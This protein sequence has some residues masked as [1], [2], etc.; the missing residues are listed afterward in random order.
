MVHADKERNTIPVKRKSR[1]QL[2]LLTAVNGLSN[3][4]L[5]KAIY[6]QVW[7]VLNVVKHS[8]KPAGS[9]AFN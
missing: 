8:N 3:S 9:C 6:N 4:C 5:K 2:C 1:I 7:V